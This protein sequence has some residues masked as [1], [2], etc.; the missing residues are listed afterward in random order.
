MTTRWLLALV[1]AGLAAVSAVAQERTDTTVANGTKT[2]QNVLLPS[3]PYT[4]LPALRRQAGRSTPWMSAALYSP[5][6]TPEPS[7]P[8]ATPV[9]PQGP[10]GSTD[11]WR[12]TWAPFYLWMSG[13]SGTVGTR[14]RATPVDASFWDLLQ[15][16]NFAYATNLDV[17]KGRFG[18]NIDLQYMDL[19][20]DVTFSPGILFS[21]AD[22]DAKL[23]ILDPEFYVRAVESERGTFDILAGFRYWHLDADIDFQPGILLPATSVSGGDDWVDPI[24]GIRFRV[25]LDQN[26]KWFLPVKADIGG[27]DV[28]SDYTWQVFAAIGRNVTLLGHPAALIMGYRKIYVDRQANNGESILKAGLSGPI[29]GFTVSFGQH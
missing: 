18:V 5:S 16:L 28:G 22:V 10:A 15:D 29:L 8:S 19:G 2:E 24:I 13:F 20:D 17:G 25:N 9:A 1:V 14:G 4:V 27:F 3:E 6:A 23:F 12:V 7:M 11:R 21:A 26:K